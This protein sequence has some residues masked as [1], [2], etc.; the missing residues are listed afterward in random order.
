LWRNIFGTNTRDFAIANVDKGSVR[1]ATDDEWQIDA[2]PHNGGGIAT[3]GRGQLHLIWFTNGKTRQGLFYKRIDSG[4]ESQPLPIGNP[5]SQANHASVAAEGRTI[6]LTWR[7]FD[8]RSYSAQLM[9]SNDG[10]ASWSEPQGLMESSGATDYPVPL[11]DGKKVL[12]VWNTAT[13]GLR[14]LPFERVVSVR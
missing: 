11:I 13:E 3:D 7:E 8:G 5:A 12:I 4:W 14:I 1:R 9:Y 2:C 10:G 6:L